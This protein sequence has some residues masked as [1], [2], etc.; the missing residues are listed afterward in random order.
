MNYLNAVDPSKY[1]TRSVSAVLTSENTT[2]LGK[3]TSR[4]E[5]FIINKMQLVAIDC[6]GKNALTE[7][8]DNLRV[9]IKDENTNRYRYDEA[10]PLEAFDVGGVDNNFPGRFV[11]GNTEQTFSFSAAQLIDK[12]GSP[13]PA[14]SKYPIQITV[15]INGYLN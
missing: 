10:I 8:H 13:I 14:I 12:T 2:V 5:D 4:T 1:H 3:L 6:E 15:V 7:P 9:Q 11:A